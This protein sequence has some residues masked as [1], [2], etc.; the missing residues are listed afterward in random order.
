VPPLDD[1]HLDGPLRAGYAAAGFE[2]A[3]LRRLPAGELRRWPSTWARRLG[4]T[5]E[6]S[7]LTIEARANDDAE[8]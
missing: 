4:H 2:V 5:R 7:A 6:R 1:A 8:W 3:R